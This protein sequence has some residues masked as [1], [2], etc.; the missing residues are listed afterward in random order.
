MNYA[1]GHEFHPETRRIEKSGRLSCLAQLSLEKRSLGIAIDRP[2]LNQ[3]PA[4][5][6]HFL[7][8]CKMK[9]SF[10]VNYSPVATSYS[11]PRQAKIPPGWRYTFL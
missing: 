11:A 10:V 7:V 3:A 8:Y 2:E 6:R 4:N 9:N 5:R 1:V